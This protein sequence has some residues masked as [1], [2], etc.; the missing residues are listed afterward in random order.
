MAPEQIVSLSQGVIL[1]D[2][3][4]P[5]FEH[6]AYVFTINLAIGAVWLLV[7][8]KFQGA[9]AYQQHVFPEQSEHVLQGPCFKG[10]ESGS[11][12]LTRICCFRAWKNS[13][14]SH[15]HSMQG[16]REGG[17]KKGT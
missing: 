13:R 7:L 14:V 5:A 4:S 16:V 15:A 9:T 2:T 6:S 1:N 17:G 8:V 3:P 11:S 10:W 12:G